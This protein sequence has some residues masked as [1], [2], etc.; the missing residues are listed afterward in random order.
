MSEQTERDLAR[1]IRELASAIHDQA[2][3]IAFLA[4]SNHDLIQA[5]Q[6]QTQATLDAWEQ[7]RQN[8]EVDTEETGFEF[9]DQELPGS[10][11]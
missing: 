4:Q 11:H 10:K 9:L 5:L 3:S 6:E 2:Q 7:I 1:G 8:E